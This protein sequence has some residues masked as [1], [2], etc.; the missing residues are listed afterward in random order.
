[1]PLAASIYYFVHGAELVT[2]PP[3][4][5]LHGAGGTHL[6]WPAQ[7]RRLPGQ[8]VFALD[9]P[10]H[11][12]SHGYGCQSIEDYSQVV[13][14]FMQYARIPTAI[15]VGHSMGGAIALHL[16]LRHPKQ[17]LGLG[18]IGVGAKMRVAP[19]LLDLVADPTSF[20]S[21]ITLV[22][23]K[24]YG[25]ATDRRLKELGAR[26]MA[27]ARP[28][29]VAGDFQACDAF[30]VMG[31]VGD[32]QVPALILCGEQDQMTPPNR[33][34]YLHDRM[35]HAEYHLVPDAGHMVILER[36][37][38]VSRLLGEFLDRIPY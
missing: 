27:E 29:V 16:A 17:V 6:N 14:R 24:S 8:R 30:D 26:R 32:I 22:T 2:R 5:L 36:P 33:S 25:S 13:L 31:E 9:L 18:L 23:E 37:D 20:L 12:K 28:T 19:A 1:M 10:G 35:P 34:E 3:V 21:A 15:V 7:I 4:V 38:V 11:G